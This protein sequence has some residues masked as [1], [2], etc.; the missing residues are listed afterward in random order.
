MIPLNPQ[1]K[2]YMKIFLVKLKRGIYGVGKSSCPCGHDRDVPVSKKDRYGFPLTTVICKYCGLI[3]S[4]PYYDQKTLKNFYN[5]EYR[6]IYEEG[7][8]PNQ[9]FFDN[10]VQRGKFIYRYLKR[11]YFRTEIANKVI[12]EIGCSAGGILAYFKSK[13]NKVFGCDYDSSYINYGQRKGLNLIVGG[14]EKLNSFRNKADIVILCHVLE[15]FG[16]LEFELGRIRL[17]VKKGGLLFIEVPGIYLIH[18]SYSGRLDNFLQ[19]AHA[20]SFT[21]KSLSYVM[22]KYKFRLIHGDESVFAI[23]EKAKR[24]INYRRENFKEVLT[25][26]KRTEKLGHIYFVEKR[27]YLL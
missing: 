9:N 6:G 2:K 1:Q 10:Q 18:R 27:L 5:L 24:K 16:N 7:I 26:L 19:N 23:F 15:H 3:R 17:L 22:G 8:K 14:V 11:N 25:Y 13:G 4:D 12:V 20:Y 21:L